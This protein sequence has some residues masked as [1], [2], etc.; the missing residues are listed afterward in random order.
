[1]LPGAE[2]DSGEQTKFNI[3][4]FK[5]LPSAESDSGEQTKADEENVRLFL[6]LAPKQA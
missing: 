1:M 5:M 4:T 6:L 2:S 3:F